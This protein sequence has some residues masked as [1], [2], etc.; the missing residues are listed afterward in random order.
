LIKISLVSYLNST[1]FR[2]GLE[3]AQCLKNFNL[4]VDYPSVCAEKLIK[5]EVDIGL[6]P[7]AVLPE[8][9]NVRIISPYGIGA[10]GKVDSVLMVS[11]Q[12]INEIDIVKL[13]YQSRTSI[14]LTRI[15]FKEFFKRPVIFEP[16]EPNYLSRIEEN[17][18]QV[19]IGDRA[20]EIAKNYPYVWDLPEQW[21]KLTELPFVF[22]AWVA[23]KDIDDHWINDLNASLK[24]GIE[25][26]ELI[27]PVL[28]KRYPHLN[29]RDYLLNKIKYDISSPPYQN[30]IKKF[31]DLFS[32][33]DGY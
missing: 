22:A 32:N 25:N 13:D 6:V 2:W 23:N 8:I 3:H 33:L 9:E 28:E 18:A 16:A 19:V 12:P 20:L 30:A 14:T 1:P 7:I 27:I 5:N 31:H 29:I 11:N 10:F 24:L 17:E 15:L 4:S 21:Y 26:R